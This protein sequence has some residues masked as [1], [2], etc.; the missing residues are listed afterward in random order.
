MQ[1]KKSLATRLRHEL[2]KAWA[3]IFMLGLHIE[4]LEKRLRDKDDELKRRR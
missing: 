4:S 1:P 2:I 3:E